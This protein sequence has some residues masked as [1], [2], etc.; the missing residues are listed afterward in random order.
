MTFKTIWQLA[1]AAAQ[2]WM[3]DKIMPMSAALSY[4]SLFSMAPLLVI[5]MGIVG[6]VFGQE[7]AQG[8]VTAQLRDLFG[9]QGARALETMLRN[10]H[11]NHRGLIATIIGF[12]TLF[13][14]ASGV[15]AQLQTSLNTIW[16]VAQKPGLSLW[17]VIRDRFMSFSM[18]LGIGF[19]LLVS[20][21]LSAALA[22]VGK[23]MQGLL[24]GSEILWQIFNFALS[25]GV[26]TLLFAM[27]F[28]ILPDA[29][30][31]WKHVWVGAA[32]T[33][34]LFSIGKQLMGLYLGNSAIG[35]TYGAAGSMVVLLIW[36]NYS[37]MILF[38]GA[39]FTYVY[40]EK[41]GGVPAPQ[42]NAMPRDQH[43]TASHP[44]KA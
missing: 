27:I 34:L 13:F 24:P 29:N 3:K 11:T 37:S 41:F 10:A 4:Y 15:F 30:I 7:A 21:L 17:Q 5:C 16:N 40:H 18:V 12:L 6:M 25:F 23:Y 22:A 19:V 32:V 20:L 1:K 35:S 31:S 39:E 26:I 9:D 28:K 14:G 8:Q 2:K 36:V 33:S 44:A 43:P 42:E 38:Y